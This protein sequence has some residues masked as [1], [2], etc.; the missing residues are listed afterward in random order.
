MKKW[1]INY[2]GHKI[3]V[4]NGLSQ[5]RLFVDGE[6]QDELFGL[7]FRSRLY[8][9]IRNDGVGTDI[10]VALG[11]WWRVHCRIFVDNKLIFHSKPDMVALD[12]M[13]KQIG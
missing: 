10:K 6:L 11:G 4:E 1:L 8:G 5:E 2:K 13:Q 7:G 3:E 12:A 9:K